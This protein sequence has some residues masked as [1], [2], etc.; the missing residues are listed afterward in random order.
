[1]TIVTT[2]RLQGLGR[3]LALCL[4]AG[5]AGGLVAGGI[6]S[7][8]VMRIVAAAGG[9]PIQGLLTENGNVVGEVT[10]GGTVALLIFAGAFPGAAAGLFFA[11]VRR[12]LPGGTT[13]KG[14]LFGLGMLLAFGGVLLNTDNPDFSRF[15]NVPFS[16]A[17]FTLLFLVMGTLVA[18]TVRV[19]EK[20]LPPVDA[21]GR[22]FRWLYGLASVVIVI[23]LLLVGVD[24]IANGEG[25]LPVL[26]LPGLLA[27]AVLRNGTRQ[28]LAGYALLGAGILA[29]AAFTIP[30]VAKLL[31][32][33]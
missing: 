22:P 27:L 28:R 20:R 29:G 23:P 12:W 6:G 24:S 1:M 5:I 7:R 2:A 14:L 4:G 25:A 15:G 33:S 16:V 10:L 3:E 30:N 21:A 9:D 26:V 18:W 19:A 17:L 11:A 8:L 32:S 31:T 13:S